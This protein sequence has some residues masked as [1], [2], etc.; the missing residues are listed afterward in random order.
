MKLNW[1]LLLMDLL[2]VA[3]LLMAIWWWESSEPVKKFVHLI[4]SI[5][6]VFFRI[7]D[8]YQ[9]YKKERRFY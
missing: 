1:K 2:T 3:Y 8:H 6:F 5:G 4:L 9:Y 7:D